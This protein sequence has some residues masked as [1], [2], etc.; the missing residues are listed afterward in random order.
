[1]RRAIQITVVIDDN[2]KIQGGHTKTSMQMKDLAILILE[3][4]NQLD[5]LKK[6]YHGKGGEIEIRS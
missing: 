6:E 2:E 4:E 5:K 3:I 1:M